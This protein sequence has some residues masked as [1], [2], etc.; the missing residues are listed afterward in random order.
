MT[1]EVA[2]DWLPRPS[3]VPLYVG[4]G[5]AAGLVVMA[6]VLRRRL[7]WVLLAVA[8]AAAGIGW[9]EYASLPSETGPLSVWWLLPVVAAGSAALA[10][11]LGYRLVSY[12]LVLL[13]AIELGAWVMIRRDGA[14]RA[15]IPTDAVLARPRG[16]GRRGCGCRD[17]RGRRR[18]RPLPGLD[19]QPLIWHRHNWAAILLT[20]PSGRGILDCWN[21]PAQIEVTGRAAHR[22]QGALGDTAPAPPVSTSHPSS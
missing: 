14:F 6:L 4:A 8:V 7:A 20:G 18:D 1:V 5:I 22:F 12:A 13:G 11:V 17:D 15:L 16:S 2:T 10:L 19:D 9:W 3:R 21:D